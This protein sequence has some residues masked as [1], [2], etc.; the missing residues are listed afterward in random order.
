M[1]ARGQNNQPPA[2]MPEPD[3][4]DDLLWVDSG[5]DDVLVDEW[6]TPPATAP[7]IETD[8][9]VGTQVPDPVPQAPVRVVPPAELISES[10]AAD[11]IAPP[12]PTTAPTR[13]SPRG[14]RPLVEPADP[15]DAGESALEAIVGGPLPPL[16]TSSRSASSSS[17]RPGQT[18]DI[19]Q[20]YEARL[21][22]SGL[23]GDAFVA[24]RVATNPPATLK[25]A[26]VRFGRGADPQLSPIQ[27]IAETSSAEV[28]E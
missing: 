15:P 8:S 3:E 21:R 25:A 2:G 18:I 22:L 13:S 10:S 16:P 12:A 5:Y 24:A 26:I 17:R 11:W 1:D 19:G 4:P 23:T 14:W 9:T 6:P 27:P 20:R 7:E 28:D